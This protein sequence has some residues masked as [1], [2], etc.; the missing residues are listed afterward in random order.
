MT[1]QG[2][3][4]IPGQLVNTW[5][6]SYQQTALAASF[7]ELGIPDL[8]K[9]GPKSS[10]EL[11]E[12]T[13]TVPDKLLM[14]LEAVASLDAQSLLTQI[15]DDFQLTPMGALLQADAPDSI[16]PIANLYAQEW[17]QRPWQEGL[18][19]ALQTGESAFQHV[20]GTTAWEYRN[21]DSEAARV[22]NA[23]MTALSR[24]D[25]PVVLSAYDFSNSGQTIADVGGGRGAFLA[26]ILNKYPQKQGILFDMPEVM[27]TAESLIA[28]AEVNNRCRLVG[29]SFLDSVP[30]GADLYN[31][32]RVLLNWGD[33]E[34]VKIT[35]NCH[36]AMGDKK[37]KLL[38]MEPVLHDSLPRQKQLIN[39]HMLSLHML[40]MS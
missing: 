23:G 36:T 39:P 8:L 10:S 12:A 34:Y 30:G 33:D 24:Q 19:H 29:G 26:A 7:I 28:Q 3:T 38:I 22:F 16:Q 4:E 9:D 5:L 1:T 21:H 14:F 37:G 15:G 11:A 27:A 31:I 32:K 18:T 20:Y 13:H 35:G 40:V 6:T 17:I 25:I 2:E